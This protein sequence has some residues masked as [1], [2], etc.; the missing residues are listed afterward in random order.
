MQYAWHIDTPKTVAVITYAG[1]HEQPRTLPQG[2][3]Q[4]VS[5]CAS[6]RSG[7]Q[8]PLLPHLALPFRPSIHY[9]PESAVCKG[10]N[11]TTGNWEVNQT[12]A[13]P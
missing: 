1:F 2:Q 9:C 11:W 6:L 3:D 4:A 10:C 8:A 12:W 13:L 7:P 5:A